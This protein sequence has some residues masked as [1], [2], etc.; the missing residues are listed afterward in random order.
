MNPL[1]DLLSSKVKAELFRLLFGVRAERLH[2]RELARQS[3]LAVGTVRQ[4]L[5][6]LARLGV[7]QSEAD[8]NR[9]Y[10]RANQRHPLYPGI[11]SLVLKTVRVVDVIRE[12][13]R[14]T[15]VRM[16]FIYGSKAGSPG[17]LA[18]D[19]DLLVIGSIGKRELER[20]LTAGAHTVD[21]G[22][23]FY[24]LTVEQF[25]WQQKER[26]QILSTILAAPRLFI[27]GDDPALS[28]L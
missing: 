24:L 3:G 11:S 26:D 23:N 8:G 28:E 5:D 7:V 21:W 2:L 1:A 12:A 16:A 9:T 22:I 6:R 25:K 17:E 15:P 27:I 13:L 18:S 10:Y 19:L 20:R 4:E 14:D